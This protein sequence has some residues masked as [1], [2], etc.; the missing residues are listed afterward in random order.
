MYV[1]KKA[2]QDKMQLKVNSNQQQYW[3]KYQRI[4]AGSAAI[5]KADTRI[6]CLYC[7]CLFKTE[8]MKG[9]KK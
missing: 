9:W 7:I 1:Y 6:E 2:C 5:S 8:Q 3:E 4:M